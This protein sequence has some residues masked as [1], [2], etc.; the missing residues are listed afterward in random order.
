LGPAA[1]PWFIFNL[2][3]LWRFGEGSILHRARNR[4]ENVTWP[5]FWFLELNLPTLPTQPASSPQARSSKKQARAQVC[6]R[7]KEAGVRVLIDRRD[8][9][10]HVRSSDGSDTVQAYSMPVRSAWTHQ[11]FHLL[12]SH[13]L[14]RTKGSAA[15]ESAWRD[16]R[17]KDG[18]RSFTAHTMDNA[19]VCSRLQIAVA[20]LSLAASHTSTC[21]STRRD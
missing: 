19:S 3:C 10:L 6:G 2:R 14:V 5:G 1:W 9:L 12:R 13:K 18:P 15:R 21:R 20:L 17:C 7:E 16:L 8:Q 11:F 4:S